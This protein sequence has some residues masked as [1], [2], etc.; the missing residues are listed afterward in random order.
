[1]ISMTPQPDHPPADSGLEPVAVSLSATLATAQFPTERLWTTFPVS[2][3]WATWW[4][5]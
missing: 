2:R 1:M 3:C 4:A 5:P